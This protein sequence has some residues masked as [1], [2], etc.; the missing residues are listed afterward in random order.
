MGIDGSLIWLPLLWGDEEDSESYLWNR[1]LNTILS[2]RF[3]SH[4]FLCLH[5]LLRHLQISRHGKM[6]LI[7]LPLL[8]NANRNRWSLLWNPSISPPKIWSVLHFNFRA[9]RSDQSVNQ[10]C[11]LLIF[12]DKIVPSE[13]Q[14]NQPTSPFFYWSPQME[15][16]WQTLA[17]HILLGILCVAICWMHDD[18][19]SFEFSHMH[20]F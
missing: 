16:G 9:Q 19:A 10:F 2:L 7:K 17:T 3:G 12:C 6:E 14:T 13:S 5:Y 8:W 4:L 11:L 1:R 20:W 15:P 18:L